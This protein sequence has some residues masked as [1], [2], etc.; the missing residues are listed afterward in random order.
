MNPDSPPPTLTAVIKSCGLLC[1]Y[2]VFAAPIL[3]ALFSGNF[4]GA[5]AI[6]FVARIIAIDLFPR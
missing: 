6:L 3:E 2:V 1:V 5:F 4:I